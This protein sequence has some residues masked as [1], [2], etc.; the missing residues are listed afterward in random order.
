MKLRI[1][2]YEMFVAAVDVFGKCRAHQSFGE[3][4]EP[5]NTNDAAVAGR[6]AIVALFQSPAPVPVLPPQDPPPLLRCTPLCEMCHVE[7]SRVS[8]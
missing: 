5:S 4:V 8:C 6:Y 3:D 7:R 2:K 1:E